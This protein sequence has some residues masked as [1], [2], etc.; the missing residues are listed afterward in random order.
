MRLHV[1][2]PTSV[3]TVGEAVVCSDWFIVDVVFVANVVPTSVVG[4]GVDIGAFVDV[5]TVGIVVV[6]FGGGGIVVGIVVVCEDG[7]GDGG[8]VAGV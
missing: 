7:G 6:V 4:S 1:L 3:F 8:V 2:N 5:G